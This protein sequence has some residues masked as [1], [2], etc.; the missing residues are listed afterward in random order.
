MKHLCCFRHLLT[1]IENYGYKYEVHQ[2]IKDICKFELNNCF[3]IF[4]HKFIDICS[5]DPDEFL[6]IN[7]S[8]LTVGIFFLNGQF[9]IVNQTRLEQVSMAQRRRF[10]MLS[11]T[12][13]L[14]A[15]HGQLI[16]RTPRHNTFFQSLW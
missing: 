8:M 9:T 16:R 6:K 1:S 2:I 12:N 11:T 15:T 5:K 3:L 4:A 7:I 14:E 10:H 13:T